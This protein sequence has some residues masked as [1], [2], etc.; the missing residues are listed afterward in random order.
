MLDWVFEI[1]LIP[2]KQC[3]FLPGLSVCTQ[4]IDCTN[5]RI[6]SL[7]ESRNVSVFY[8]D[9]T[10]AFDTVS[11]AKL[12][13]K[14]ESIGIQNNLLAWFNFYLSGTKMIVC[15]LSSYSFPRDCLS[16]VTQCGIL[17]PVSF[18]IHTYN[19]PS[20]LKIDTSVSVAA[21]LTMSKL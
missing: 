13:Q 2:P 5:A 16:G 11:H 19:L 21:F 9:L 17:S 14:L 8:F 1:N 10:R 3:T 18:L 6:R 7:N 20:A 12:L 4:M 15:Y